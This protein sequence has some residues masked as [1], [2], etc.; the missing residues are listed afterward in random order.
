MKKNLK[1]DFIFEEVAYLNW[2]SQ[3]VVTSVLEKEITLNQALFNSLWHEPVQAQNLLMKKLEM[4]RKE[5]KKMLNLETIDQ[6]IYTTG[7]VHGLEIICNS[8]IRQHTINVISTNEEFTTAIST[9]NNCFDNIKLCNYKNLKNEIADLKSSDKSYLFFLSQICYVTGNEIELEII[10]KDIRKNFSNAIIVIDGSQAVGNITIDMKKIDSDYYIFN[11][12]KWLKGPYTGV[13]IAKGQVNKNNISKWVTS[14]LSLFKNKDINKLSSSGLHLTYAASVSA[15]LKEIDFI[16]LDVAAIKERYKMI[17][18]V[19]E[20]LEKITN[21]KCITSKQY[22]SNS[23]LISFQLEGASMQK[24]IAFCKNARNQGL[25]FH[26]FDTKMPMT[27]HRGESGGVF[28]IAIH[29]ENTWDHV[30][31]LVDYFQVFSKKIKV[32]KVTSA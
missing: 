4:G 23:G 5:I 2:A 17:K 25:Y 11:T 15:I 20:E 1:P 32:P 13:L 30:H 7:A 24:Q 28:R 18:N 26:F 14:P 12:N 9:L 3:T 16:T 21:L 10:L 8:L 22:H 6:V 19:T 27:G 31:K 29:Y